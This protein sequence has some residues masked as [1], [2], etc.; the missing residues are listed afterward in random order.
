VGHS[1]DEKMIQNYFVGKPS[2]KSSRGR[3]NIECDDVNRSHSY[4]HGV[5]WR[6]PFNM[7]MKCLVP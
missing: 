4:Q 3:S 6:N 1:R 2:E 5:Q 7:V